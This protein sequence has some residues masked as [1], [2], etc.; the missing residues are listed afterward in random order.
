MWLLYYFTIKF[1][2]ICIIWNKLFSN[3][4][5]SALFWCSDYTASFTISLMMV[6]MSFHDF[7]YEQSHNS[8]YFFPI[9]NKII[10]HEFVGNKQKD[11][12]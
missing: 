5:I 12:S 9:F 10:Y 7:F 11:E 3:V 2:T 4:V 1:G 6:F 8:S